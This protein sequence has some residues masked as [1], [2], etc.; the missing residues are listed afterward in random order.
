LIKARIERFYKAKPERNT[1]LE[2]RNYALCG[3]LVTRVVA[4]FVTP[5]EREVGPF[6]HK[7]VHFEIFRSARIHP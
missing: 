5:D 1:R 7:E 2:S 3:R 6:W 4:L